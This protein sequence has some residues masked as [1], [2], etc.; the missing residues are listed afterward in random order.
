[1][2]TR[3]PTKLNNKYLIKLESLS[4]VGDQEKARKA[5]THLRILSKTKNSPMI[6]WMT[7]I[8]RAQNLK[9]S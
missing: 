7:K 4:V 3:S 1:M 5:S 2:R 9:S 8:N 6:I